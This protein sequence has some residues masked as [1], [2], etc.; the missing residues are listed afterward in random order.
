M[1]IQPIQIPEFPKLRGE[2]AIETLHDFMRELEEQRGKEL[3]DKQTTALIKFSLSLI[4]SIEAEN[5]SNRIMNK[6]REQMKEEKRLIPR[7][8]RQLQNTFLN[9]LPF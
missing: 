2:E 9:T 4:S 5:Q 7:L 3:T 6:Y 1:G 8:K